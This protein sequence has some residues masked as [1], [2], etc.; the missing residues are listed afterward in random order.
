MQNRLLLLALL[1]GPPASR[2]L[3]AWRDDGPTRG[4][5]WRL[6]DVLVAALLAEVALLPN[7]CEPIVTSELGQALRTFAGIES[8]EWQISWGVGAWLLLASAICD[9]VGRL[10]H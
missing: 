2:A 4:S 3:S 10:V 8:I 5:A 6:A 1:V 9:G 7:L